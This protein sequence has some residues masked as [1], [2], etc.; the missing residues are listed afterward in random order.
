[1]D[2]RIDNVSQA[3]DAFLF[4]AK[5]KLLEWSGW[6][7][8]SKQFLASQPELIAIGKF[9]LHYYEVVRKFHTWMETY[10]CTLHQEELGYLRSRDR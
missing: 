8:K 2:V 1:M 10:F 6:K 3:Q 4:I 9:S 5:D 7:T